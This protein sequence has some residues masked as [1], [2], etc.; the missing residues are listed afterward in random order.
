MSTEHVPTLA[1]IETMAAALLAEHCPTVEFAWDR[2]VK[3]AGVCKF[4]PVPG[5]PSVP[6][7]ITLSRPIFSH[8]EEARREAR[9]TLLHEI[10]HALAGIAAGH[11]P[12]WRQVARSLGCSTE[13]CH[14]L[15]VPP[16]GIVRW[17]SGG[18]EHD[19]TPAA[20]TRMPKAGMVYRCRGCRG[21]VTYE[22]ERDVVAA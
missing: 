20:R 15:P 4:R 2:A 7:L 13:R 12:A 8:S 11:G 1:E 9:D 21:E 19:G 22:R 6:F 14:D 3:R 17:C 18:C 16:S 10:A 5:G